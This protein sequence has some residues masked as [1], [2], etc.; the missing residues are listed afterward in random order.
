MRAVARP[1]K[2]AA[3][4][5]PRRFP[6]TGLFCFVVVVAGL[7]YRPSDGGDLVKELLDSRLLALAGLN[8]GK[9]AV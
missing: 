8:L 6:A 4:L 9:L 5:R 7:R 2:Q 3:A 1:L